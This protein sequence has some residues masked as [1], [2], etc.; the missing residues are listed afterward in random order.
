MKLILKSEFRKIISPFPDEYYYLLS[1]KNFIQI[2]THFKTE[3]F[4][5]FFSLLIYEEKLVA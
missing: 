5:P 4:P 1:V 2:I 3:K